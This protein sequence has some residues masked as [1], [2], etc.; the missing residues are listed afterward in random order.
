MY[1]H[2]LHSLAVPVTIQIIMR[3]CTSGRK[4]KACGYYRIIVLTHCLSVPAPKAASCSGSALLTEFPI[5]SDM[6]TSCKRFWSIRKTPRDQGLIYS[7]RGPVQKKMCGPFNWGDRPYF[8]WKKNWRPFSVITVRGSALS[9][10]SKTGDLFFSWLAHFSHIQK[11]A[12]PFW[13]PFYGGP[14]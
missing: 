1:F 6:K 9:F 11:F 7:Q 4:R 5:G 8:S 13:G 2:P 12:A 10:F 3:T 14:C